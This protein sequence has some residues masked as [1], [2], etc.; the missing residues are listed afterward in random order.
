[1]N[2]AALAVKPAG[3]LVSTRLN[4]DISVI[5]QSFG[6]GPDAML[7]WKLDDAVLPG[8]G[9]VR[10]TG[11]PVTFTQAGASF[12][13]GGPHVVSA[14]L[15]GQDRLKIDNT[16]WRVL[17]VA[18]AMKVLIVEGERGMNRLSGSGSLLELALAPPKEAPTEG[19][20]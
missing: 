2:Q 14:A 20:S 11:D 18:A 4:N 5:V 3:N 6:Q 15:V 9:Q 13:S 16:R 12:K 8:G 10:F 17:D 7:Q 1:W 19:A